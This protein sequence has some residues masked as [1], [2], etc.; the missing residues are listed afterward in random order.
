M[1]VFRNGCTNLS[2]VA[3]YES[4]SCLTF[5]PILGTVSLIKQEGVAEGRQ[6]LLLRSAQNLHKIK[7]YLFK[8]I[9]E[10]LKQQESEGPR[11]H[12]RE[13]WGNVSLWC[14]TVFIPGGFAD[15]WCGQQAE[16]PGSVLGREVGND[17]QV[18]FL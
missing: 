12:R 13:K 5:L 7:H 1:P 16:N 3:V 6:M 15:S 17:K 4:H 14:V 10:P 11:F 9:K 8:G 18:D 2:S